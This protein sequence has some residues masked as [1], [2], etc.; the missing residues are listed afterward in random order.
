MSDPEYAMFMQVCVSS[1]LGRSR[2]SRRVREH[3]DRFDEQK[4]PLITTRKVIQVHQT[5]GPPTS[6]KTQNTCQQSSPLQ[7]QRREHRDNDITQTQRVGH[8][9]RGDVWSPQRYHALRPAPCT[10]QAQAQRRLGR[11]RVEFYTCGIGWPV[12]WGE[13][14]VE[15]GYEYGTWPGLSA[16]CSYGFGSVPYG[17]GGT[18]LAPL[19]PWKLAPL[20]DCCQT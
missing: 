17:A 4:R 12:D 6:S 9:D 14:S 13:T 15:G 18:L 16:A 8:A 5:T 7:S 10:L 19:P 1:G 2:G 20:T 3:H 11:H